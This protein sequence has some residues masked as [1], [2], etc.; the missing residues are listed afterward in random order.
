MAISINAIWLRIRKHEG[1][2]FHTKRGLPFTYEVAHDTLKHT[3]TEM[4]IA[5]EAFA[6]VLQHVPLEGPG[7]VPNQVMGPSYVWAILHDCRIRM[8]DY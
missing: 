4:P 2:T 6:I 7:S 8:N 5:K 1:E 3:R